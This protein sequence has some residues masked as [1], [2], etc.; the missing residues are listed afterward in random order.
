MKGDLS[1][2][3][4]RLRALDTA[5]AP[6]GAAEPR[7]LAAHDDRLQPHPAFPAGA[8]KA[9]GPHPPEPPRPAVRC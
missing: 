3:R 4:T 7:L 6:W 2:C 1:T 8:G 9:P 5:T